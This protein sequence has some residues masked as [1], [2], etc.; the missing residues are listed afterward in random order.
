MHVVCIGYRHAYS[1]PAPSATLSTH[2]HTVAQLK[3]VRFQRGERA[4]NYIMIID[5]Q[6]MTIMMIML[7]I[8]LVGAL[9]VFHNVCAASQMV[10]RDSCSIQQM[11]FVEIAP[12]NSNFLFCCLIQFM[13]AR[14]YHSGIMCGPMHEISF[15]TL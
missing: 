13:F 9:V 15:W 3:W 14:S 10:S 6:L 2:T 5:V 4:N 8:L 12:D 7:T 1:I 11:L